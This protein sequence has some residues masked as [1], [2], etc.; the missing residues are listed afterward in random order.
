MSHRLS[1]A[2]ITLLLAVGAVLMAQSGSKQPES[3]VVIPVTKTSPVDGKKMYQNY[4]AACHGVDGKGNGPVASALKTP[5]T[6]LTVLSR[7][8]GGKFPDVHVVSVLE[9]GSEH[10]AHGSATMPVWGPILGRMNQRNSMEKQLR[11]SNLS[12]YIESLQ[13][14]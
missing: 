5:P 9:F 14:K 12:Q 3:K 4:C 10:P 1:L 11:M 8:N 2:A 13:V 7:N 6:D